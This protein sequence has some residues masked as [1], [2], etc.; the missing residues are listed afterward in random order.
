MLQPR[1]KKTYW[2]KCIK[3]AILFILFVAGF[4]VF[5]TWFLIF[6]YFSVEKNSRWIKRNLTFAEIVEIS[7]ITNCMND[8]D[9]WRKP[10]AKTKITYKKENYIPKTQSTKSSNNNFYSLNKATN[11]ESFKQE[12]QKLQNKIKTNT[13]NSVFD[14]HKS[15]WDDYESVID[16]MAKNSKN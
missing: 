9:V 16:I 8:F 3:P 12:S 15:I 6:F 11:S 1:E 7:G 2:N 4:F 14:W 13:S 5:F 10:W